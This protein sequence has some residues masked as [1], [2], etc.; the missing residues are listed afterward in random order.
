MAEVRR[1]RREPQDS[2]SQCKLI[3]FTKIVSELRGK[4]TRRMD[5][6]VEI[7]DI[8]LWYRVGCGIVNAGVIHMDNNKHVE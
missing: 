4:G 6:D 3:E 5:V 1:L 2:I 8:D 7:N